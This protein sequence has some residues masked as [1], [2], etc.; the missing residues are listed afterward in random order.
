MSQFGHDK[1]HG[2]G[3]TFEFLTLDL[4]QEFVNIKE[5][6]IHDWVLFDR[7]N[8]IYDNVICTLWLNVA[9]NLL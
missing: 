6:L 5:S 3:W 9:E 4:L 2:I 8:H 1:Q 7:F